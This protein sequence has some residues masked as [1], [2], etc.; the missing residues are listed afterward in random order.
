MGV[1]A[2]KSVWV[3]GAAVAGGKVLFMV[4]VGQPKGCARCGQGGAD[5]FGRVR[6]GIEWLCR[7]AQDLPEQS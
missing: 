2:E 7:G 3:A 1:W 5:Y 4:F 6:P